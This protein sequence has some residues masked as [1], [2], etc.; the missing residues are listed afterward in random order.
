MS[1]IGIIESRMET[2]LGLGFRVSNV[3][4]ICD[5]VYHLAH[6]CIIIMYSTHV[7]STTIR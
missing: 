2:A 6:T 1:Y 3:F 7:Q 5:P 4:C